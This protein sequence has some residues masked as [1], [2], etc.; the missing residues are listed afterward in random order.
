MTTQAYRDWVRDMG[1]QTHRV[2]YNLF[3]DDII[4]DAGGYVGDFTKIINH[5]YEST[6]HVYEPVQQFYDGIVDRFKDNPKIHVHKFGLGKENTTLGIQSSGDATQ[7]VENSQGE[8]VEVKDIKEVMDDLGNPMIGLFK[9]NIEGGEYDL[10]DRLLETGLITK[11]GNLQIQFH[12]F[13]PNAEERYARIV[14]QLET[15]HRRMYHYPFIWEGWQ[16]K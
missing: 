6:V 12:D 4:L 10:L 8:Q 2:R 1:D 7:L 5:L 3:P 11:M 15:T 9:I 16:L 13:H 14:E